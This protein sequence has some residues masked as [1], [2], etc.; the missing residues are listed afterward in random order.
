M[1]TVQRLRAANGSVHSSAVAAAVLGQ[2]CIAMLAARQPACS[3]N[4]T[5]KQVLCKPARAFK[6]LDR[7]REQG[8]RFRREVFDAARWRQHR[9]VLCYYRHMTSIISSRIV[10]GLLKP[11]LYVAGIS[12]AVCSYH[13]LADAAILTRLA[14]WL[15]FPCVNLSSSGVFSISTFALSLLLVFRINSSYECWWEARS[16]WTQ[17][18]AECTHLANKTVQLLPPGSPCSSVRPVLL[19][20]LKAFPVCLKAYLRRPGSRP[21][22]E[23]IEGLLQ[24][25]EAS[26]LVGSPNPANTCLHMIGQI[27]AATD[28]RIESKTHLDESVRTLQ[29]A[30]GSCDQILTTP[31]PLSYTRHTSRFLVLWLTFLPFVTW[32]ELVWWSLPVCMM[33]SFLLFGIEEIG[34]QIEEPFG[35]LALD[36]YCEDV[37]AAIDQA[38][39]DAGSMQQQIQQ[40]T[41]QHHLLPSTQAAQKQQLMWCTS[42]RM[43]W[44]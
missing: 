22:R 12:L 20:F 36:N 7:D 10:L 29:G 6:S 39:A 34:M 25:Q 4:R 11:M 35:I 27:I 40:L 17:V 43:V 14:P 23:Q 41:S 1:M 44:G 3:T 31:L 38:A 8:R 33:I 30:A 32:Q 5:R 19:R 21:L 15:C 16:C 9:S 18:V 26:L 13:S 24:P 37:E 28:M 42:R 2:Q